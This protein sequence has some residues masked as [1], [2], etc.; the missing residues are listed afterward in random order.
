MTKKEIQEMIK[1][2]A[3]LKGLRRNRYLTENEITT[4]ATLDRKKSLIGKTI[5][6]YSNDGFVA[7]SYKYR[8][9]ID[10]IERY[11]DDKGIKH[12]IVSQTRAQR[13]HGIA[14]KITVNNRAYP[15]A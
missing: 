15:Q 8:A 4:M 2:A 10:Y 1:R 12:F 5:R 11:Y 9:D 6:I 13:A 3:T 7:N 14:P